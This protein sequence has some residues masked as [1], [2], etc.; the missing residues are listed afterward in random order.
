MFTWATLLHSNSP[1]LVRSALHDVI[2]MLHAAMTCVLTFERH[3]GG[4]DEIAQTHAL[5][6][7]SC[8][9]RGPRQV[10]LD[11]AFVCDLGQELSLFLLL[12]LTARCDF[13]TV[14]ALS[15]RMSIIYF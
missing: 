11:I 13:A 4:G 2:G 12:A 5:V 1:P 15:T 8:H 3:I 6:P 7:A 14:V 10:I 9:E